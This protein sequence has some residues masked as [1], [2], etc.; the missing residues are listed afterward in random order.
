LSQIDE[1]KN[2]I[3]IVDLVSETVK[4]RRTGKNYIGFCPFHPN[5]RT[6][7]FVVFPDSG[8]WRCFGQCAEGGDIFS[9]LMKRDNLDF[10]QA[11]QVLA[12]RAGIKLETFKQEDKT[13]KEQINNLHQLMQ[14]AIDY[15]HNNLIHNPIGKPALDYLHKRGLTDETIHNFEMGYAPDSWDALLQHLLSMNAG[16]QDLIDVGLVSEQ[17]DDKGEIIKDG[18]IFDRFRN[19]IMIPIHD[20]SGNPIGFGARIL[21]PNDVPKFLN[22]PQTVLFD[23]GKTLFGLNRAKSSIREKN[24]AVIVEGYL[25]VIILHQAGFTNTVSPMGTALSTDQAKLLARQ[26]K[27]MILALDADAAGDVATIRGIDVIRSAVKNDKEETVE[28][29]TLI[30]QERKLN[31]DIRITR[32]PEGMDPDEVV[33]RDPSEWQQILDNAKPVVIFM[34]ETLAN[35]RNLEDAKTKSEIAK[36]I[37]P[38]IREVVDPIERETYRQQLAR[39]LKID[40]NLLNY[41]SPQKSKKSTQ[42]EIPDRLDFQSKPSLVFDPK[43]GIYSKEMTILQFLYHFYNTPGA[44]SKID[45]NLRKYNLGP[46][47]KEDF[48]ESDLRVI[49]GCYFDGL[50][51]DDELNTQKYIIENIPDSIRPT[52]EKIRKPNFKGSINPVDLDIDLTRS[53]AYLRNEKNIFNQLELQTLYK[54]QLESGS[55]P[56]EYDRLI[57]QLIH[58]RKNLEKLLKSLDQRL[59]EEPNGK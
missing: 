50:N 18:K 59:T 13:K 24:Q 32:I 45:R 2:Q 57:D 41:I 38:L 9:F 16:R 35:G 8:S 5:T 33:L 4:L 46:L 51:Q 47:R 43:E 28:S 49:A 27:N 22:S 17:R 52:F 15:Y 19:R 3:D 7:S 20:S 23:K 25:D 56:E 30:R 58:E 29:Q 40:E 10:Q 39:F 21:D 11:L 36:Q 14:N 48:E 54:E 53:V 12:N 1:I 31:A 6:P 42:W 55:N 44:I 26:S 34:M 37:M